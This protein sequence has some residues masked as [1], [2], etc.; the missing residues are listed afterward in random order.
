MLQIRNLKY[1][2]GDLA[3]LNGINWLI[4]PAKRAA[5]IGPNGAGKTT[6]LRIL[7]GELRP[8]TG[9][10]IKPREYVIG[11]LPQEEIAI[12]QGTILEVALLGRN[13]IIELEKKSHKIRHQLENNAEN[14]DVLLKQLGELEHR[15]ESL[16]GYRLES[17]VKAILSGL[18]FAESDFDCPLS[19][20]SGGWRMRVYLT[21]LL[22]KEPD[23][24]LLDE[25]TNH[26]DL[27]SLEWL[28]QYLL[29]FPGSIVIVSHDRYFIDRLAEEIYE[30]ERGRLESYPGNYFFY[31]QKK[32]E[33]LEFLQKKLEETRAERERQQRFIN[34][35][36]YKA[37]K[38]IQVQSRVK[39][40]EKLEEVELPPPPKR[41][42]FH[43]SVEQQSY[44]DVLA[45]SNMSFSYTDEW[46]LRDINLNLY[47]GDKVAMVGVNGAGKTT[48]T[49]LIVGQLSPQE[50]IIH[51]GNRTVIGYYAQ[52]Q[53]DT[54]D[55]DATV[56]D[57][58]SSTVAT[59]LVPKVRDVLGIFQLSGDAVFKKIRVLSGGEKARVSLAKI[60]LSPVNFLIMDEPTNHL[61]MASKVALEKA[62][63]NYDGTLILI[64]HDRY[65]LDKLIT[66]VIEL[67]DKHIREYEGNYTNYL[68]KREQFVASVQTE[69]RDKTI[70]KKSKEAKRSQAEARQAISKARNRLHNEIKNLEGRIEELENRILQL[71]MLLADPETYKNGEKAAETQKEY[72]Q[73]KNELTASMERWEMAF[74]ELNGLLSGLE[75]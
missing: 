13:E 52:H 49:R 18:G 41:I 68:D 3:L 75:P 46:V 43:L 5:L 61:D 60:L 32:Q 27:P 67:K 56:Y 31:E 55:L 22:I 28:E 53:V 47:R 21:R 71:E 36:R 62:L 45:I 33:K 54:L 14:H 19:D 26:L 57:E 69:N 30:L 74:K 6:L 4:R 8:E 1:S 38:A 15:Y 7:N 40:L 24:L 48:L 42:F 58:V 65:F 10:I 63:A 70:S 2:I 23:L 72:A 51:V 34:R 12:G 44:K 73:S 9:E 50:G 16:D 35:F 11:Y 39:Q 25:P 64:S 29:G 20:F 59:G 66:R 37:T 17:S